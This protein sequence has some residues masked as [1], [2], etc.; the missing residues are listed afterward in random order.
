[1][2]MMRVASS[3][4]AWVVGR[5]DAVSRRL[6]LPPNVR[7]QVPPLRLV[8]ASAHIDGGVKATII[9]STSDQ[10]AADQLRD[11]V[12]GTI[13]FAKLQGNAMPAL[14]DTLKSIELGGTGTNVQLSFMITPE[15]V[16]ALSAQR[17]QGPAPQPPQSVPSP[18][19]PRP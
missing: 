10:A 11:V 4:N 9:A 7:Q 8:S 14:Q 15:T 1:M 13:S 19:P 3:G 17:G 16:Q 18:Q 2:G 12:R 5:F 6:G